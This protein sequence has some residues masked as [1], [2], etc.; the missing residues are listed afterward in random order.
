MVRGARAVIVPVLMVGALVL[1]MAA[2][3]SAHTHTVSGTVGCDVEGEFAITWT[4][5]NDFALPVTVAL[6]SP[7]GGLSQPSVSVGPAPAGSTSSATVTQL[8]P[9]GA[10]GDTITLNTVATWEDDFVETNSGTVTLGD[11]CPQPPPP[12]TTPPPTSTLPP[13][14]DIGGTGV[15]RED[16]T[17]GGVT[18]GGVGVA[19]GPATPVRGSPQFVG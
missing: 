13:A 6:S 5:T 19:G 7:S 10:S 11:P 4:I 8:L 1:V 15:V 12:S 17:G 2:P 18:G 16:V 3:A 9:S 14:I